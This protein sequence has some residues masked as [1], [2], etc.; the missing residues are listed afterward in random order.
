MTEPEFMP[1]FR[2]RRDGPLSVCA[3]VYFEK[4]DS[5]DTQYCLTTWGARRLGRR[6]VERVTR[7]WYESAP[8]RRMKAAMNAILSDWDAATP[9]HWAELKAARHE[10]RASM[11]ARWEAAGL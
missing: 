1:W 2:V 5:F 3:Q 9:E 7:E 8:L 6:E 4:D 10:L 11:D